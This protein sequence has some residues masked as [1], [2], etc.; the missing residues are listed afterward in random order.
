MCGKDQYI[1]Q[2]KPT[3][4]FDTLGIESLAIKCATKDG[5]TPSDEYVSGISFQV[6]CLSPLT[7]S[8]LHSFSLALDSVDKFHDI[9]RLLALGRGSRYPT[10]CSFCTPLVTHLFV[11]TFVAIVG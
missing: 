11:G 3:V 6:Y 2:V 5:Y 7:F 4:K 1:V 8:N 10:P 9:V